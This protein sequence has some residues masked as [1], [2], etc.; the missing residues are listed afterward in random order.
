MKNPDITKMLALCAIRESFLKSQFFPVVKPK[1]SRDSRVFS[2]KKHGTV[3]QK[4][5][6]LF[7]S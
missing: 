1:V 2:T 3:K 5:T 4:R 7:D 6:F